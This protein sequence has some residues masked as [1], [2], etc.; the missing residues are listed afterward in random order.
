MS[1]VLEAAY[2]L[3]EAMDLQ[4][5]AITELEAA[6]IAAGRITKEDLLK[7]KQEMEEQCAL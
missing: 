3:K 1:E 5:N 6:M 2:K 4:A 7:A